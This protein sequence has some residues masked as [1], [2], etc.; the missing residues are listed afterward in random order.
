M[1]RREDGRYVLQPHRGLFLLFVEGLLKRSAKFIMMLL[2]RRENKSHNKYAA[3]CGAGTTTGSVYHHKRHRD[4]S[5][6]PWNAA[7]VS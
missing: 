1:Q 5:I 4:S 6:D 2:R 3:F 7:N